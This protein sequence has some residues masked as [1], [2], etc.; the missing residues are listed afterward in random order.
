[1]KR[2]IHV[3]YI[4]GERWGIKTNRSTRWYRKFDSKDKAIEFGTKMAKRK[5]NKLIIHRIDG[6][7]YS[8]DSFYMDLFPKGEK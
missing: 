3:L 1:M 4:D 8:I 6:S 2:Q 7:I 5:N